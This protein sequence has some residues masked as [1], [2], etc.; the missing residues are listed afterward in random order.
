MG[1]RGDTWWP[2]DI[3][4]WETLDM[5]NERLSGGE[6]QAKAVRCRSSARESPA[7][8]ISSLVIWIAA[9]GQ[10]RPAGVIQPRSLLE[11]ARSRNVGVKPRSLRFTPYRQPTASHGIQSTKSNSDTHFWLSNHHPIW[12]LK[13]TTLRHLAPASQRRARGGFV[14][15]C[16]MG[17]RRSRQ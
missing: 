5:L 2:P 14:Q 11:G 1:G 9:S 6:L 4:V 15:S 16:P 7:C 10:H 13:P 3:C 17:R 12:P 8:P